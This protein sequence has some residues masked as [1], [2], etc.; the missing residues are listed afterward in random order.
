MIEQDVLVLG[1]GNYLMGDEGLGV[2]LANSIK[3][4][5]NLPPNVRVIDGGTGGFYL[6]EYIESYPNV[7]IVDATLDNEAGKISLIRPKFATDFPRAMTTHDIGLRDVLC[8]IEL[9]GTIPNVHLFTVSIDSVQQQ[10]I[11]LSPKVFSAMGEVEEQI[12]TLIASF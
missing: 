2:H 6:M 12:L 7:V 1:I 5:P 8:A 9:R 4:N 10:G 3:D 11:E